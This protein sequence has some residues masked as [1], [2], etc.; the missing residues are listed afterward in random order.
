MGEV[1]R[2]RDPALKREVA[3]KVLPSFVSRDPDRL[4]RF[5]QEAQAAAALDHPNILAVHQ[6]GVFQGAPYLVSELLTGESLR[7]VLQRG[8]LPARKAID[9]AVQIAHGLAAAHDKGIVHRDLK[10]ENLF[11]TKDSRVKI[12]DFGLA[13]LIQPQ[14]DSEANAPTLT[15]GTDPGMV[16]GTAG[17]MSPEQVRGQAVDHR[18]DI[19][20]FGT[21]LYE[22]LAGRRAFQRSTSAETMTAILNDEPP[23]VS[24]TG[25][26]I[27]PALQRV[28]HRCLEKN[29]EQRFHSASD[30][31]FALDALS[32]HSEPVA[33]PAPVLPA[34]KTNW[35]WVVTAL[36]VAIL[37]GAFLWWRT[38]AGVPQITSV[39]QLTNDGVSKR[40]TTLAYDGSRLYF[41]EGEDFGWRIV[42]V[43]AA[44]G[45]TAALATT[46]PHPWLLGIAPDYSGVLVTPNAFGPGPLW[47]QPLPTGAPR[48]LLG[49]LEVSRASLFPDGKHVVYSN[50]AT[51]AIADLDGSN[52]QVVG[53]VNGRTSTPAISPSGER[54]RFGVWNAV[55]TSTSLWELSI[56][57]RSLQQMLVRWPGAHEAGAGTWTADG[58]YFIFLSGDEQRLDLWALP[59]KTGLWDRQAE[60][61]RLTSGPLSYGLPA[62]SRDGDKIYAVGTT[63]RGELVRFDAGTGQPGPFLSGLP[64]IYEVFSRDGQWMAYISYPD[65]TLWRCRADGSERQQITYPPLVVT[66]IGGISPDNSRVTFSAHL[67]ERESALFSA[68]LQDGKARVLLQGA[69]GGSWSPDGKSLLINI[70]KNGLRNG[71]R[72]FEL[73]QIDPSNGRASS[74]P[75]GQS[76]YGFGWSAAGDVVAYDEGFNLRILNPRSQ[77]WSELLKG[78]C[79]A[80]KVST[81]GTFAYCETSDVPYHKIVRV[82]LSDRRMETVMEIKGLRRVADQYLGTTLGVA[83]DG[84]VLLTR[85]LG[86]EEVYA[87]SVNW[88]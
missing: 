46:L 3:I 20:A 25:A 52:R 68:S 86:S 36:I 33:V 80:M 59:E 40:G 11:V 73:Q 55:T 64:A 61:I 88:R 42:E 79:A 35:S 70:G 81:D 77:A 45:E 66:I 12:L 32:S 82:R 9:Y 57:T 65:H 44:G 28:V 17:Y 62:L 58:H 19:F 47:W 26:N 6:F 56:K 43:A 23:A 69:T 30:L 38:P 84:S 15:Q 76:K 54:V 71:I 49:D 51:I 39:A 60:P 34:R 50:G 18:T 41:T 63:R 7:H 83:P 37:V 8:P 87:L 22:M 74:F 24:Q 14:T 4:S 5:E 75:G 48:R 78:P 13:K 29:P 16:M 53:T 2:A 85:D 10:P 27:P 1:Y 72:D 67:P 31:A 21:I